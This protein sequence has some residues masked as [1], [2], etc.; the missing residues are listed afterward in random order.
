MRRKYWRDSAQGYYFGFD[1]ASGGFLEISGDSQ[2]GRSH[3]RDIP[4]MVAST[5]EDQAKAFHLGVDDIFEARGTNALLER[6]R[7]LTAQAV[8]P[9]ISW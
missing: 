4:V 9:R 6:L 1:P 2:T 7:A 3:T 5:I 8:A